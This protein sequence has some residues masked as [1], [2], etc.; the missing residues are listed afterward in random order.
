MS[1]VV[2][3]AVSQSQKNWGVGSDSLSQ[4]H[5]LRR[6]ALTTYPTPGH[7]PV[8][9]R[10]TCVFQRVRV[11]PPSPQFFAVDVRET[12]RGFLSFRPKA[13]GVEESPGARAFRDVTRA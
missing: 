6:G 3:R 10:P 7:S 13:F 9:R 12:V 1:A 5:Y 4:E 2:M 11:P 8:S